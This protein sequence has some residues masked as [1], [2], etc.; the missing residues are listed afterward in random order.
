MDP[1]HGVPLWLL[2][3]ASIVPKVGMC[4]DKLGSVVVGTGPIYGLVYDVGAQYWPRY[5]IKY[6]G[7]CLASVVSAVPSD[8]ITVAV[9]DFLINYDGNLK[10]ATEEESLTMA[11]VARAREDYIGP[12][13]G[14]LIS[15]WLW[16]NS[17]SEPWTCSVILGLSVVNVA[18]LTCMRCSRST[19]P[20]W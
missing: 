18:P 4:V 12:P 7:E 19:V 9:G 2:D 16:G 5:N 3:E 10:V 8:D 17:S 1:E 15:V 6:S 11:V 20:P 14:V 13:K